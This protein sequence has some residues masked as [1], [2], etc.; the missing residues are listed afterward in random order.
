M[1]SFVTLEENRLSFS[2]IGDYCILINREKKIA[3]MFYLSYVQFVREVKTDTN[4]YLSGIYA[5]RSFGHFYIYD[6]DNINNIFSHIFVS[7]KKC[8][9]S[10]YTDCESFKNSVLKF[11]NYIDYQS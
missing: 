6:Y 3:T 9:I 5:F 1:C 4:Y 10:E 2:A 8:F 11:S 7:D